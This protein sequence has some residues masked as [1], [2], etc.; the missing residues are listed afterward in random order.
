MS[1]KDQKKKKTPTKQISCY[2]PYKETKTILTGRGV[3]SGFHVCSVGMV[4]ITVCECGHSHQQL[5]VVVEVVVK[6]KYQLHFTTICTAASGPKP[7]RRPTSL[8]P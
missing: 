5:M 4:F 8:L 3:M 6:N 7:P 1:E 2:L